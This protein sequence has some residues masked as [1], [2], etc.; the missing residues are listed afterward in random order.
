MANRLVRLTPVTAATSTPDAGAAF[1]KT[2]V[3]PIL[4]LTDGAGVCIDKSENIYVSD[5]ANHVIYRYRRGDTQS[6]IFAGAYGQSGN[7]DGAYSAARFNQPSSICVDNSGNI[8]LIDSGNNAVRRID[9]NANVT[10]VASIPSA[11][12]QTGGIAVDASGNV[13]YMDSK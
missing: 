11:S 7:L 1:N 5:Y 4:G 3:Q 12:G 9:Q 10:T 6:Y 8:Y 2:N 13:Y